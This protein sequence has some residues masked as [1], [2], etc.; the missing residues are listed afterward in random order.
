MTRYISKL[1]NKS[2]SDKDDLIKHLL[3]NYS[4]EDNKEGQSNEALKLLQEAFPFAKID[5]QELNK[6]KRYGDFHINM[7][8]REY[9]ADFSFY[10]G[11]YSEDSWYENHFVTIDD[12]I[13]NYEYFIHKKDEIIN[14]INNRYSPE[15]ISVEQMYDG[16]YDSP[17]GI[18]FNFKIGED[19]YGDHYQF[20]QSVSEF[21]D[22]FTGYFQNVIEGDVNIEK[23]Y[24][25]SSNVEY[26]VA[27]V[28]L[29]TMIKRAKKMRIEILEL[30]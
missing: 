9:N 6:E 22:S 30:R 29:S 5:I 2:F 8:W 17:S 1:D 16:D 18:L 23:D 13:R 12:A 28:P 21:V 19:S 4:M 26:Y 15:Y 25:T 20:G 11:Y 27:N 7:Q 14:E 3:E 10:V 24:S